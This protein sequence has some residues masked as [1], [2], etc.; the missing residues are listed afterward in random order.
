[1]TPAHDQEQREYLIGSSIGL[2]PLGLRPCSGCFQIA[3]NPS[4]EG[5]AIA[6]IQAVTSEKAQFRLSEM[7]ALPDHC[8]PHRCR[9]LAAHDD[10]ANSP[11]QYWGDPLKGTLLNLTSGSL[12]RALIERDVDPQEFP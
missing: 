5:A 11:S 12:K 10:F 1:M 8:A 6:N 9:A 3:R 2:R 7:Q 4:C